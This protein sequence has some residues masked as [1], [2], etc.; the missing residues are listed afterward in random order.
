VDGEA[1]F[2]RF[3]R[4]TLFQECFSPVIG[5]HKFRSM[6]EH[7]EDDGLH[8]RGMG[9]GCQLYLRCASPERQKAETEEVAAFFYERRNIE[10]ESAG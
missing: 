2:F 7:S 6:I 3:G 4:I 10:K 1:D 5:L 8:F 9:I